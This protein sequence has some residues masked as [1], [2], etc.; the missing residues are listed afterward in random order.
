MK[1]KQIINKILSFFF[2]QEDVVTTS[3]IEIESLP[4][5]EMQFVQHPVANE[6]HIE[7]PIDCLTNLSD[8]VEAI[9]LLDNKPYVLL[10]EQCSQIYEELDKISK[11]LDDSTILD[12]ID[13]QKTRIREALVLSG[14]S[15]IDEEDSFDGL[16]HSALPVNGVA[17]GRTIDSIIESGITIDERVFIKSIVKLIPLKE[18]IVYKLQNEFSVLKEFLT[19][20]IPFISI[21]SKKEWKKLNQSYARRYSAMKEFDTLN[22]S[23]FIDY[24]IG[25]RCS[26]ETFKESCIRFIEAL[27]NEI[28]ITMN[29]CNQHPQFRNQIVSII[30]QMFITGDVDP[31]SGN[32]DFKNRLNELI[33]F[34]YLTNSDNLDLVSIEEPLINGKSIDFYF[35]HRIDN[36]NVG[37]EIFTLQN[38]DSSLQEDDES[39]TEFLNQRIKRK[40]DD[41]TEG[42]KSLG[43]IDNLFIMPIVEYKE[44]MENF[45][46]HSSLEYS[47]PIMTSALFNDGSKWSMELQ[48]INSYLGKVRNDDV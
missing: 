12:F 42:L 38:V 45:N 14:A 18:D 28:E 41:K 24:A 15:L 3:P 20:T 2:K 46:L 32:S 5:V 31:T 30:T 29:F 7:H 4:T 36:I 33:A 21:L 25:C 37:F 27:N 19:N 10:A 22:S 13:M 47:T 11:Q 44:G 48:E 6:N 43:N 26:D 8:K 35:H 1:Y 17:N 16:K 40:Y 9:S 23:F 39:M 34:N